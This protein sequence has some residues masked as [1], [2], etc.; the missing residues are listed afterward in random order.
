MSRFVSGIYS[1]RY[2]MLTDGIALSDCPNVLLSTPRC[3]FGSFGHLPHI[4]KRN[5]KE[6]WDVMTGFLLAY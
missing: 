2:L 6:N 3:F 1:N 5:V 4:Y